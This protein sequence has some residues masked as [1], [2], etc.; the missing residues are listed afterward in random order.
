MQKILLEDNLETNSCLF[1]SIVLPSQIVPS[2][3]L[4]RFFEFHW[5]RKT[6]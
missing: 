6:W 2:M 1:V 3:N 4:N 5:E